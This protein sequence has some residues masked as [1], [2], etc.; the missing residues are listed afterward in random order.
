MD[1]E[2]VEV[3]PRDGLQNESVVLSTGDKVELIG[4]L[5]N[6]GLLRIETASFVN[7]KLVPQMADGDAV[8]QSL[9]GRAGFSRIGLA[10]NARGFTR[11]LATGVD[12]INFSVMATDTFNQKNQGATTFET[13][14]AFE[15]VV[16]TAAGKVPVTLTIGASFGCPYEG[17]TPLWRVTEIAERAAAA[18]ASELAL[19]DTIGVAD[20]HAVTRMVSAVRGVIGD[21]PI[22]CHF[23]NTRNTGLANA[24]A[25]LEAGVRVLDASIGGIGGCPFAPQ[26]TGNI[27][28]EDLAY[29]LDRMG[30]ETGLNLDR[31]LE[32][33]PWLGQR[34]GRQVPGLLSRAGLFP[35]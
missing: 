9:A 28:T 25:A 18:G 20:P 26:A 2:I 5:A 16:V 6:A 27:P 7:P 12:E 21:V 19:G 32:I 23:H 10:L 15:E 13:L 31:L 8:M 3:G 30:V 1:I 24:Y 11:A 22:R 35:G 17:E 4:M 14:T 29:M 33:P 34:L